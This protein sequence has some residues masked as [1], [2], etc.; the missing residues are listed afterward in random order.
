MHRHS[1]THVSTRTRVLS[2][3]VRGRIQSQWDPN[4]VLFALLCFA[5]L[6]FFSFF[7]SHSFCSCRAVIS[8]GPHIIV[9]VC[10]S[11]LYYFA[12]CNFATV[13]LS[14]SLPRHR[15]ER[16]AIHSVIR[17]ISNLYTLILKPLP[18][19]VS[20]Q[21]ANLGPSFLLPLFWEDNSNACV[22][23]ILDDN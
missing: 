19:C 23:Y 11:Q 20:S 22:V 18:L 2:S 4:W 1:Y 9:V 3:L 7:L 15:E 13:P 8:C 5:Y 21:R 10:Q 12:S 16:P 14:H 6:F 17:N